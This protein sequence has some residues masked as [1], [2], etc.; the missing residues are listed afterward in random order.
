MALSWSSAFAPF[1]WM[2]TPYAVEIT[3]GQNFGEAQQPNQRE[4]CGRL[5]RA[6]GIEPTSV[7]LSIK[8]RRFQM[9]EPP[10]LNLNQRGR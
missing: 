1:L 7:Y 2:A 4:F 9:E 5:E 6:M 3:G 8:A 10:W